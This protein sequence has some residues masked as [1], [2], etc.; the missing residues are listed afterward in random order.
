MKSAIFC[1]NGF[2][3]CEALIVVDL[4]RRAN[5]E[6]DIISMHE[7]LEVKS[8]HQVTI[9]ADK[10]FVDCN[11]NEYDILIL[12][13]GMPGTTHL[14]EDERLK[15]VLLHHNKQG[16]LLCAICAAPSVLGSLGLLENKNATCFPTFQDKCTGALIS[17]TKVVQDGNIITGKGLG[18]AIEFASCIIE[19]CLGKEQ[20][21]KILNQIQY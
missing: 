9:I 1:A 13:G 12:P 4:L 2:E 17:D 10:S 21:E 6:I 3:E 20:A 18:A 19:N 15:R 7:E 16:K 14:L 11:F 8:S 5:L